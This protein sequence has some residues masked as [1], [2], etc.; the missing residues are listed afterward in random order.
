MGRVREL[1]ADAQRHE[2][3][4]RP[5][6]AAEARKLAKDIEG[7]GSRN[8][9]VFDPKIISIVRKYGIA[10]AL[11]AGLITEEMARQMQAQGLG[12]T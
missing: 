2:A 12:E 1:L 8:Y 10:G 11:G 3:A 4:G 6:Y 7:S 5:E 9:V